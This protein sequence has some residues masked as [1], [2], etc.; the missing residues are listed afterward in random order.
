MLRK[1]SGMVVLQTPL[2]S[3]GIS[4][5]QKLGVTVALVLAAT[6]WSLPVQAQDTI[7]IGTGS[8]RGVYMSL[9]QAI[10]KVV[11][12][13]NV[14]YECKTK[15]TNG[16]IAN[17]IGLKKGE[18]DLGIVQSDV[19]FQAIKGTGTFANVGAIS[20]LR[21]V[22]S[23]HSEA[24]AVVARAGSG[25]VSLADLPGKRVNIGKLKSGT[26][27]TM[28]LLFAAEGW[29]TKDFRKLEAISV[30]EQA[31]SFCDGKLD[32]AT[33]LAGHPNSAVGELIA[34]CDARLVQVAGPKVDRLLADHP[35][36]TSA[37]ISRAEYFQLPSDVQ[38]IG[39]L[40][41]VMSD[42]RVDPRKIYEVT[43]S[44]FENLNFIR[45]AKPPF[46][47]LHPLEMARNG[48]T[49]PRHPG[50]EKYLRDAGRLPR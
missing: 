40:A 23:A 6:F 45:R 5:I 3:G 22:F 38:T 43:R 41:T 10:C 39:V 17:I 34:R 4:V 31:A 15:V 44:V 46:A 7:I 13:R 50:A 14:G 25:V 48:L 27:S 21:S 2:L 26:N 1:G 11:N 49:A 29:T 32:V 19:Q 8:S 30:P 37:I 42:A 20:S 47:K 18:Y 16:S 36:Y 24:L 12:A 35:Y 28:R 9:G 33:F